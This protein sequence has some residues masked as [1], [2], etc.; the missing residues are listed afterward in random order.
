MTRSVDENSIKLIRLFQNV[1]KGKTDKCRA[2]VVSLVGMPIQIVA[3][4]EANAAIRPFPCP[5]IYW[6]DDAPTAISQ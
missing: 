3:S 1:G 5:S 2:A 6:A 4:E